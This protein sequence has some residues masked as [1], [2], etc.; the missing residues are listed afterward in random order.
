MRAFALPLF[1][2]MAS[3]LAWAEDAPVDYAALMPEGPPVASPGAEG[4]G[5]GRKALQ[6]AHGDEG[7]QVGEGGFQGAHGRVVILA[8]L[9]SRPQKD[10]IYSG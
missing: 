4:A 9:A 2:A 8:V 3:P 6:L 5:S 1:V 7:A 10:A